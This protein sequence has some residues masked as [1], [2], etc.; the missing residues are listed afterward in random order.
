MLP[1]P[2]SRLRLGQSDLRAE[3]R[4][5]TVVRNPSTNDVGSH[6]LVTA[7]VQQS[8]VPVLS[9]TPANPMFRSRPGSTPNS[10]L[11]VSPQCWLGVPS[12]SALDG[13]SPALP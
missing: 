6:C 11:Y 13:Q 10:P 4:G 12:E 1:T 5:A 9:Q 2:G 7:A 8:P 3:K